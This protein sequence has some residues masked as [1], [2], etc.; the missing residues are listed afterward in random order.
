MKRSTHIV[1]II[2]FYIVDSV[3][4]RNFDI[5]HAGWQCKMNSVTGQK[6]CSSMYLYDLQVIV[7]IK[8]SLASLNRSFCVHVMWKD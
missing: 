3:K 2:K 8:S 4:N 6:L 5:K 7:F 1:I